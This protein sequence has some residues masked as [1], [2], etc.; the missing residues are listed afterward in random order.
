MI[1]K[2]LIAAVILSACATSGSGGAPD[3]DGVAS[4]TNGT[5]SD[6]TTRVD[7]G[8]VA[9]DSASAGPSDTTMAGEDESTTTPVTGG[10]LLDDGVEQQSEQSPSTTR[11]DQE[12]PGETV[13]D[14]NVTPSTGEV[15][16]DVMASV[17]AAAEAHSGIDRSSMTVVRAE[18][19]VWP[20][21]SLGCPEPGITYTMATVDGYWVELNA[22]DTTLDYRVG[23][24]G[25]M[26]M[27]DSGFGITPPD[28]DS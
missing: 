19:V 1:R 9:A 8:T 16:G 26:K 5:V 6:S 25:A 21:G 27:C 10:D 7:T 4:D 28:R 2:L 18:S 23:T 24:N 12:P 20:D 15:P 13:P 22:G 14:E 17:Y 3:G 11:P